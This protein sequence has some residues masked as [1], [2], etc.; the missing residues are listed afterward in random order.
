MIVLALAVL[1]PAAGGPGPTG[2]LPGSA[3]A[4]L[5]G[6]TGLVAFMLSLGPEPALWAG[7][8]LSTGPYAWLAA[9]MPGL[10]GLRVPARFAAVVYVALAALAA[11]GAARLLAR[12]A[13]ARAR[14]GL[15]IALAAAIVGEG[16]GGPLALERVP[17]AEM[18]VDR[19]VYDWLR[20][21][22]R[23]PMLELPMGRPDPAVRYQFRT[24]VHGNRIVNGYSGYGTALDDFLSGPPFSEIEGVAG[25]VA[26]CRALG[27]RYVVVHGQ[28]YHDHAIARRVLEDIGAQGADVARATAFGP[29]TVFE[30]RAPG[31]SAGLPTAAGTE[32]P[33]AGFRLS[34]SHNPGALSAAADGQRATRWLSGTPQDGTEWIRVDF[35]RQRRPAF[36]SLVMDRRSF[37]D[38]P[39]RL[40]IEGSTDGQAF[41]PL[42]AG[43]VLTPLALSLVQLPVSPRIDLALPRLEVSALRLRQTGHT[44]RQ[45][46]WSVHDIRIWE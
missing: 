24:L 11:C 31:P 30:L 9:V 1:M 15:V 7:L 28:L 19:A 41:S 25:A 33:Q 22:P 36:L 2:V 10:D 26:M 6:A 8:R 40:E 16:W 20:T 38:Y 34:A 17:S 46:Y 45:W 14:T 44:P 43:S 27:I 18:A 4:G 42:W 39:R 35:D 12:I 5:Y 13:S 3:A 21:Q 32:I 37:G 23:G 29:V